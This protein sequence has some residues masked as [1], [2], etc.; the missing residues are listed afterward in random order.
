M[1]P[2]HLPPDTTGLTNKERLALTGNP[3]YYRA[4]GAV[5]DGFRVLGSMY[6][7]DPDRIGFGL[8]LDKPDPSMQEP[9]PDELE[10]Y[11]APKP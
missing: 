1:P 10:T 4:L 6:S 11:P 2:T 8:G 9:R 5:A 7:I 3:S